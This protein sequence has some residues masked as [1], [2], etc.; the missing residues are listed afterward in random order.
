MEKNLKN[1]F[2]NNSFVYQR[3]IYLFFLLIPKIHLMF[4]K[5]FEFGSIQFDDKRALT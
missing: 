4:L 5:N 3:F 1:M 2:H